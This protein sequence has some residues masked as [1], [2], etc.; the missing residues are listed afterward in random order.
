MSTELNCAE[1]CRIK[2][3]MRVACYST[4]VSTT[5]VSAGQH[6]DAPLTGPSQSILATGRRGGQESEVP[7]KGTKG[8]RGVVSYGGWAD[9]QQLLCFGF[10]RAAGTKGNSVM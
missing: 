1:E 3:V 5:E 2:V 8:Q 10:T 7:A 9:E 4:K 6:S